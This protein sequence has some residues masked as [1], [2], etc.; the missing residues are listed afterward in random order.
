MKIYL[1]GYNTDVQNRGETP[2]TLSAAYARISRDPRPIDVLR[3]EASREVEKARRSNRTIVFQYGHGS[4]AE[5]A[6]FNFDLLDVSRLAAEE[7]QNFRLAS[8]TE[9][10]QRYIR[11]GEDLVIPPDLESRLED[12]FRETAGQL[13]NLYRD[14]YTGMTEGGMDK[15]RAREDARYVL[16]LATSCQMGMTLNARELEHMIRRLSCH[17]FREVRDIAERLLELASQAAPSLFLFLEPTSMDCFANSLS[18]VQSIPED[19]VVLVDC[20]DDARVGALLI[21]WK[22][23]SSLTDARIRWNA[24]ESEEQQSIFS[25]VLDGLGIHDSLPREWEFFRAEFQLVVSSSAYAQLKRHRMCSRLTSV[26]DPV[27]GYTVP[28]SVLEHGLKDVFAEGMEAAETYAGK[29]DK[30]Y[31]Y[32]LTNAHRRRVT[33]DMNGRELHHFSRLREDAHAQ[34]DIRETAH[35]MLELLR[36]RAPLTFMLAG[37]KSDIETAES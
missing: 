7:L 30:L 26:Y 4:V 9:K 10:S 32:A 18:P 11:I 6:V 13:F 15:G 29:M 21:Q 20:D 37:G 17:P 2:E 1:A 24:M 27:L 5:H 25:E 16:P 35:R 23:G 28:Q 19:E 36:I 8:F 33:L 12:G 22:Y 14:I 3:E 31:P 34:W